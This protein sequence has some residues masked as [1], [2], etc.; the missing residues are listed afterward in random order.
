MNL[1]EKIDKDLLVARKNKAEDTVRVLTMVRSALRNLEIAKK[2]K[3]LPDPEVLTILNKEVKQRQDSIAQF[4]KGGRED[5][6]LREDNEIEILRKYLPQPLTEAEI[7]K[8]VVIAITKTGAQ[9]AADIGKV[10]G[11]VMPQLRGR[12]DGSLI[13]KIVREELAS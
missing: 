2:T 6:A 9:S 11:S 13:Q 4:R 10:M 3:S 7:K 12:A 5:L 8:I 1:Q